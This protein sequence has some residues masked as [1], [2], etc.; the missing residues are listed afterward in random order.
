MPRRGGAIPN[1]LPEMVYR[2]P[3]KFIEFM[4][5]Q[6]PLDATQ[7]NSRGVDLTVLEV[8]RLAELPKLTWLNLNTSQT[9]DE[10]LAIIGL[11]TQLEDLDVSLTEITDAGLVH[12]R[13]LKSLE[14]L[15]IKE[16]SI[17]DALVP[18]LLDL[19]LLETLNVKSIPLSDSAIVRLAELKHLERVVFSHLPSRAGAEELKRL[20][21]ECDV[22]L[23][24]RS[25]GD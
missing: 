4:G 12:L 25:V 14:H 11:I 3:V 9:T 19:P 7:V 17:T 13:G 15:R 24:G 5:Q 10:M 2:G 18:V 20:R 22:I 6:I 8:E 23:D 1:G 16:N 21:P